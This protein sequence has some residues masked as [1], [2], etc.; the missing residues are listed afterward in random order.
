MKKISSLQ[1]NWMKN[2]AYRKEYA[3]LEAELGSAP[4]DASAKLQVHEKLS[5]H[6]E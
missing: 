5:D 1:K 6:H 2:E 3:A 4:A